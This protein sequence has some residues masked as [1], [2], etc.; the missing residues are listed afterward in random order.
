MC[1]WND[2]RSYKGEWSLGKAHGQ[3]VETDPDGQIYHDGEWYE[4]APVTN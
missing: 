4:D 1:F 3:G 2:G